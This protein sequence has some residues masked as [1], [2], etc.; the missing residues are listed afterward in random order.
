MLEKEYCRQMEQHVQR[1]RGATEQFNVPDMAV[2]GEEKPKM[3]TNWGWPLFIKGHV[4][5][6]CLHLI[7]RIR[8]NKEIFR[9]GSL[10]NRCMMGW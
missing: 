1:H 4:C 10:M 3:R 2:P 6:R 5:L 7:L 9:L 8:E